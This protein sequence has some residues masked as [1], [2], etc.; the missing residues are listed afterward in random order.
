RMCFTPL[1]P[2]LHALRAQVVTQGA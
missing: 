2:V 1:L